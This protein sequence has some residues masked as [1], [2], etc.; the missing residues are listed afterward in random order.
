MGGPPQDSNLRFFLQG[1]P[2]VKRF[3]P[4]V[5]HALGGWLSPS[6]PYRV[7]R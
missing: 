4:Q 5:R 2:H 3:R 7:L 6:V 1:Q